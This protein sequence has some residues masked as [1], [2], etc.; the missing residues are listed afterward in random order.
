MSQETSTIDKLFLELA[1]FTKAT[2]PREQMLAQRVEWLEQGN[3]RL[4]ERVRQLEAKLE[5]NP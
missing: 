5:R 1:Q 4:L 3:E 2:T